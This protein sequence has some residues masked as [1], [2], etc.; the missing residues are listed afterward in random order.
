MET[1]GTSSSS[2]GFRSAGKSTGT[3]S[4]AA[5]INPSVPLPAVAEASVALLGKVARA[6]RTLAGR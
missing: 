4:Y 1:A 3:P 2:E 6:S 5:S